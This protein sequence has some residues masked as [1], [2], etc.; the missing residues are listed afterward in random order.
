MFMTFKLMHMYIQCKSR[1]VVSYL[2]VR[3]V[4]LVGMLAAEGL[5]VMKSFSSIFFVLVLVFQGDKHLFWKVVKKRSTKSVTSSLDTKRQPDK[6]S[7]SWPPA[8]LNKST[9]FLRIIQI[10]FICLMLMFLSL[11][12]HLTLYLHKYNRKFIQQPWDTACQR[13]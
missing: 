10:V 3:P 7:I 8:G 6:D 1:K 2:Q 12:P 5:K 11:G 9:I 13:R 4:L